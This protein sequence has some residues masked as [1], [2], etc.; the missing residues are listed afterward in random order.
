[1]IIAN[2]S[3]L[4]TIHAELWSKVISKYICELQKNTFFKTRENEIN[5]MNAL[6]TQRI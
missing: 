4:E 3:P 6:V 1:M 2:S 5:I